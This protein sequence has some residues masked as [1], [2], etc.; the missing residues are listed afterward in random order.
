VIAVNRKGARLETILFV[1]LC[2]YSN[3]NEAVAS[4][5]LVAAHIYEIKEFQAVPAESRETVLLNFGL[6]SINSVCNML[7][8]CQLCHKHFDDQKIGI[9]PDTKCW[10][11]TSSIMQSY[12]SSG[13]LFSQF[14]NRVESLDYISVIFLRHRYNAFI[15]AQQPM[16]DCKLTA[17]G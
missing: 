5:E 2:G 7:T 17:E 8:M 10:I 3:L 13:T 6:D 1:D 11:I 16:Q 9:D 15:S 14:H 12:S 4:K